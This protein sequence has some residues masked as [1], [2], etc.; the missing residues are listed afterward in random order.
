M[1][2]GWPR[3][4]ERQLRDRIECKLP[5]FGAELALSGQQI[6]L[7]LWLDD[8]A[9]VDFGFFNVGARPDH[10]SGGFYGLVH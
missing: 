2:S 4:A 9:G 5:P 6:P 8:L 3:V 10:G 1:V 7:L